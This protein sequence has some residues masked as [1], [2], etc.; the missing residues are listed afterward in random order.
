MILQQ[1]VQRPANIS[2]AHEMLR[3]EFWDQNLQGPAIGRICFSNWIR[4]V[5]RSFRSK[6][7]L[8]F[9]KPNKHKHKYQ[10]K[11]QPKNSQKSKKNSVN[12]YSYLSSFLL[13]FAVFWTSKAQL[14]HRSPAEVQ[15][16]C[17]PHCLPWPRGAA[18]PAE[19]SPVFSGWV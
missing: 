15:D 10:F 17:R 11:N 2:D 12:K 9:Q 7:N 4:I 18:S 8:S 16:E 19:R 5:A 3:E 1:L 14:A 13:L 6:S